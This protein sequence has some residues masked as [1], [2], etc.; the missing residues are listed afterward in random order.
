MEDKGYKV[1]QTTDGDCIRLEMEIFWKKWDISMIWKDAHDVNR[2][3]RGAKGREQSS[4][5]KHGVPD[6]RP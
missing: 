6:L 3:Q 4:W 2:Q 1:N 5:E